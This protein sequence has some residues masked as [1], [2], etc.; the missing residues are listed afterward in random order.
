M[1]C[2][3]FMESLTT[4]VRT[5]FMVNPAMETA[6]KSAPRRLGER[7]KGASI[8]FVTACSTGR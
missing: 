7:A 5:S 8:P 4:F 2:A 3:M 6:M 1:I